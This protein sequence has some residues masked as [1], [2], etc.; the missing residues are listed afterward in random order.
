METKGR[1]QNVRETGT[2]PDR[3]RDRK[4]KG[5][6]NNVQATLWI[7]K[8]IKRICLHLDQRLVFVSFVFV[9]VFVIASIYVDCSVDL[10]DI[11]A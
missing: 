7:K 4:K 5:Q 1:L 9:F 8:L 3:E 11:C 2:W 6:L 10:I